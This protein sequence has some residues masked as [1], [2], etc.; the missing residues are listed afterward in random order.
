MKFSEMFQS[1]F[2]RPENK[3]DYFGYTNQY[4]QNAK[5]VINKNG[6][7]NLVRVG[8]KQSLFHSLVTMPWWRF[9]LVVFAFY[10]IVNIL[11]AAL[12]LAIDFYGIGMTADYQVKNRFLI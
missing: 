4:N 6:T 5:R 11:F 2:N 1:R 9:F 8:E 3:G 10:A 7:F 12:Y